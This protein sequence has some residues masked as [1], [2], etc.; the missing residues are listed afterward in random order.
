[1]MM[2][3]TGDSIGASHNLRPESGLLLT[4]EIAAAKASLLWLW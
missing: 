1:M 4:P 3:S 2:V